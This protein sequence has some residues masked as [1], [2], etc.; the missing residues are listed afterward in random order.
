M[1]GPGGSPAAGAAA[2]SRRGAAVGQGEGPHVGVEAGRP[3]Q[4]HH[5]QAVQG[6]AVGTVVD[7][8]GHRE[9]LFRAL[10]HGDVVLTQ[11][12]GGDGAAVDIQIV[13]FEFAFLF[14]DDGDENDQISK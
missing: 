8:L 9:V 11:R 13:I 10:L 4:A 14:D 6:R 3:G 7:H 2:H 1:T 12:R 5:G